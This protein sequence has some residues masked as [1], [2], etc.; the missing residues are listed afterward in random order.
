MTAIAPRYVTEEATAELSF[1]VC[2]LVAS[3]AKYERMLASFARL[4]FDA[5]NTEF[6][7]LDNR[8]ANRFEGY[9]AL[10]AV[11]PAC[12]GEYILF[13]HD[14]IELVDQGAE[15]LLDVLRALEDRDPL[16]TVAGNAGWSAGRSEQLV[17]HLS[18]PHGTHRMEGGPVE[19]QSLDEN[20]LVLPRRRMTF[21]SLDLEGYHLFGTDLCLQG[22]AAGGRAYVVPFFLHHHSG[23]SDS[24]AFRIGLD[25]FSTKYAH[26]SLPAR[27]RA[28]ATHVYI[29]ATGQA[30]QAVDTVSRRLKDLWS[31][32]SSRVAPKKKPLPPAAMNRKLPA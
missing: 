7:A 29:G 11:F 21:P 6:L 32:V 25:R 20:F 8:D 28:P 2:T 1:S 4:G 30:L 5:S 13:T 22:R 26:L 10:R 12:R 16:W 17:L 27:I 14:D 23:G 15:E 9:G 19:V 3:E 24:P 18:D 31:R